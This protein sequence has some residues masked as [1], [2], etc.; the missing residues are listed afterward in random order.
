MNA[1]HSPSSGSAGLPSSAPHVVNGAGAVGA[2]RIVRVAD[3][4]WHAIEDDRVVGRGD[5]FLR[6][7]GRLFAG[8]D[9]WQGPVF[10]QLAAA[11]LSDLPAPVHTV[12][13]EA[14]ADLT[15]A[16]RRAGF[17]TL[18]R[19]W[20]YA[21]PTDPRVTGLDA[22]RP[23]A[24]ATIVPTGEADEAALNALDRAVR[25]EIDA[26]AGWQTM[27]AE[28]LFRPDS[29]DVLYPERYTVAEQDGRYVALVRV[30]PIVRRPRIGL[31]AVRSAEQRRGIG[32]ALLAHVLGALH[33]S[34]FATA[35]AE[36][37]ESNGAATALFEGIGARRT[38]SSLELV[39]R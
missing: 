35:A 24:G 10:D 12:V 2:V 29:G 18:R 22:A 16:W 14:D 36:V 15:A 6:P 26:A 21:V 31:L 4:Q 5:T 27:P 19:E 34:G 37:D 8:V 32:R 25:A 20:E 39:R 38:V 1:S 11:M 23:P 17:S 13:D 9:A 7:D 33:E 28:V 30:S 3:T